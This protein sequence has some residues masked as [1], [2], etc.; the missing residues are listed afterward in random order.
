[1]ITEGKG[2]DEEMK[3]KTAKSCR[4]LQP[5]AKK[6]FSIQSAT[7]SHKGYW[8]LNIKINRLSL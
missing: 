7:R 1:M 5:L 6:V 2:E 4:V 8:Q 3:L